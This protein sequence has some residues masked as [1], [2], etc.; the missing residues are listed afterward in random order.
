MGACTTEV[1]GG[2][3]YEWRDVNGDTSDGCECRRVLGNTGT[4]EPDEL[5]P[6]VDENCDGIDGVIGDALFV[7]AGAPAGGNGTLSAP[8]KTINQALTALPTSGRKYVLVAEGTYNENLTL[9]DG[10]RLYG[11]YSRDFKNRDPVLH[12]SIVQGVVPSGVTATAATVY[13]RNAGLGAAKTVIAGFNLVGL[14]QVGSTG[15]DQDGPASVTVLVEASGANVRVVNNQIQAGRGGRGG[16]GTSGAQGYGRQGSTTLNGGAGLTS[17]FQNAPCPATLSRAGG[18]GGVNSVCTGASAAPG[19]SVTCP[20]FNWSLSPVRGKQAPYPAGGRN[21]V[22]GFDWSYDTSSGGACAHVTESG[23]PSDIQTHDGHTG[24]AGGDGTAGSGGS[25]A[26]LSARFGSILN[27]RWVPSTSVASAGTAGGS[28]EAGGG[29]GAGGG[30]LYFPGGACAR[31]EYGATGGGGGAGGCGGAAGLPGRSGGAS[32][33]VLIAGS[34]A[35]APF[36]QSNQIQRNLGGD[37]GNGGFGGPGGLGGAGGFGGTST[38]WSGS[39]AGKGGEGGNGG[40]GGGGGGGT[41]GP[42][43]GIL[44]SGGTS[45]AWANQNVFLTPASSLTGGNGGSGGTSSGGSPGVSG[46]SGASF[47]YFLLAPCSAGCATGTVCDL[48]GVCIPQ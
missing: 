7:W 46:P 48:N 33:A 13:I 12:T 29:G 19:G 20:S 1:V 37:G 36:V 28:G 43:F 25:S 6:F 30:T 17:G 32:I 24:D 16:R 35:Q 10:A 44:A 21:G 4:D 41:G 39:M 15:D 34:P 47:N 18:A 40:A 14:D 42:S 23:F 9:S 38:T 11:G 2:V 5:A 26:P 3:S 27:T 22:G 45:P 31:F 8:F